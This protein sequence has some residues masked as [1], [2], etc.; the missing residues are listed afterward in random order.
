VWSSGSTAH[1]DVARINFSSTGGV[2]TLARGGTN[3]SQFPA[4]FPASGSFTGYMHEVRTWHDVA[5]Q[6]DDLFDHTRNFE[7]VS[8]QN[9]TGSVNTVGITNKANYSSLSAHYKLRENVVLA[10][11]YNYIVDSTT[12]GNTAHP[13][14]FGSATGKRYVVMPN[15]EKIVKWSPVALS[16]TDNEIRTEDLADKIVD[17]GY[18]SYGIPVIDPVNR[19]IKNF[20]QDLNIFDL[21]G[22]PEDL[23]RKSYTGPFAQKWHDITAQMGLAPSATFATQSSTSWNRIRSGGGVLG[24]SVSGASGDTTSITDLNAFIKAS[25]NFNDVFGG[26]FAFIRQFIPARSQTL[27]EGIIIENHLLERPKMKRTFG[28][29]ESTGTGYVGAPTMSGDRGVISYD[30][31]KT[32][33]NQVPSLIDITVT[34]FTVNNHY[35]PANLSTQGSNSANDSTLIASAATTADFQGYQYHNGVQEFLDNSVT[36]VRNV[37]SLSVNSS[38]NVPRFLPTRIGRA[39][40]LTIKPSAAAASVVEL[41]TDALL[42]SP[43]ATPMSANIRAVINGSVRMLAR[44]NVFKTEMPALRFDFPA[45]GNGDN[46]FEATVGNIAEGRG[47]TIK[48]KDVS[49]TTNLETGNVEFE[50]RLSDGV[51]SLTGANKPATDPLVYRTSQTIVDETASGSIGIVPIRITNLFNNETTIFRVAINSDSTKD[52]ELIRQIQEQGGTTLQ[53]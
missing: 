43:T 10:G 29:R 36:T 53:S 15:M 12:A 35:N 33:N 26:M 21:L 51:R 13:I 25:D 11:Q 45:S 46:Y 47:R 49:F 27:G 19:S 23:Y 2:G 4:Y 50:L 41:T 48:E 16:P 1:Y 18:V 24:S 3:Y 42:I 28:L 38:T 32:P 20:E 17:T 31:G 30:E 7:S 6:N 40:P 22:D 8:F 37:S 9:S 39:L 52:T 34:A 14:N 5:L 44:G